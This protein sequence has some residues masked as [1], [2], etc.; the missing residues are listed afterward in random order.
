MKRTT[1]KFIFNLK[2]KKN[3][4]NFSLL[5]DSV[6]SYNFGEIIEFLSYKR[7]TGEIYPNFSSRTFKTNQKINS[8]NKFDALRMTTFK[9]K[10]EFERFSDYLI[11]EHFALMT[12]ESSN[13]K[14]AVKVKDYKIIQEENEI[15]LFQTFEH[16][17]FSL[18][19]LIL[20]RSKM[21]TP[22]TEEELL[23]LMKHLFKI[24]FELKSEHSISHGDIKLSN[25]LYDSQTKAFKL[26]DF[27]SSMYFP[28]EEKQLLEITGTPFY[29]NN[30][31][32]E[33]YSK[34]NNQTLYN[35]FDSDLYAFGLTC[36][37][38]KKLTIPEQIL[39]KENLEKEII[40]IK[41][42]RSQ[43]GLII[44]SIFQGEE[45]YLSVF[46]KFYKIK[47][48]VDFNSIAPKVIENRN[49]LNE[50]NEIKADIHF[51]IG[52]LQFILG[53]YDFSME[54]LRKANEIYSEIN[55]NS[56]KAKVCF[57]Q[58]IIYDK[59]N[60]AENMEKELEPCLP[61][62]KKNFFTSTIKV[63]KALSILGNAKFCLK[64]YIDAIMYYEEALTL[65]EK[66]GGMWD[67]RA[68]IV[69][70]KIG[71][72]YEQLNQQ[73]EAVR[74]WNE[75][76]SIFKKTFKGDEENEECQ[77]LHEKIVKYNPSEEYDE[78]LSSAQSD[79][80]IIT[81]QSDLKEESPITPFKSKESILLNGQK[82]SIFPNEKK[83]SC[84]APT[85]PSCSKKNKSV[86]FEGNILKSKFDPN[87]SNLSKDSKKLIEVYRKA[88]VNDDEVDEEEKENLEEKYKKKKIICDL[89]VYFEKK[90]ALSSISYE[91]K[92]TRKNVLSYIQNDSDF[93]NSNF[94]IAEFNL[95]FKNECLSLKYKILK[96][97]RNE[98]D[99]VLDVTIENISFYEISNITIEL[100]QAKLDDGV[101]IS[102]SKFLPR[103]IK[104]KENINTKFDFQ[105]NKFITS[106]RVVT[107]SGK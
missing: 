90:L 36:L 72:I 100:E 16:F 105:F 69:N 2:E 95:I 97:Y 19:D 78:A 79:P 34:K 24:L 107:V 93:K 88:D 96:D 49:L 66:E 47:E 99:L 57:I 70:E 92:S 89:D 42:D 33:G 50:E 83:T 53:Q 77:R 8:I 73:E 52:F 59:L 21:K 106:G 9:N 20:F 29:F 87:R 80:K 102:A 91:Y 6:D 35:P 55:D 85:S 15:F 98:T 13:F 82:L 44:N 39:T 84:F 40:S 101:I 14:Y 18:K 94:N 26:N 56:R 41:S 104:P 32:F 60:M 4:K 10:E 48:G 68:A 7:T 23:V 58:S 38:L 67:K 11:N 64:K 17:D 37:F 30:T 65:I 62:V 51:Q 5:I 27:T 22:F 86:T 61:F 43:S 28:E 46:S 71:D 12:L 81:S 45:T 25:F 3:S 75:A 76:F 103:S 31:L 1:H 74:K 63:I 54:N